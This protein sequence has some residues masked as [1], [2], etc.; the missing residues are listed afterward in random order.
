MAQQTKTKRPYVRRIEAHPRS[1]RKN[2]S[3]QGGRT[4]ADIPRHPRPRRFCRIKPT[5]L[6]HA[7]AIEIKIGNDYTIIVP[8]TAISAL[9]EI[10]HAVEAR[11]C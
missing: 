2:R 10:L 9:P 11:R 3:P 6:G 1:D 5:A 7:C 4:L 8:V